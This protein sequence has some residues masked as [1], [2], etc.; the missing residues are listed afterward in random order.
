MLT[1]V[2]N[3]HSRYASQGSSSLK[4]LF[5]PKSPGGPTTC[6]RRFDNAVW[7][8]DILYCFATV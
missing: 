5:L 8:Y 6:G 3:W 7:I 4:R 1:A 2:V